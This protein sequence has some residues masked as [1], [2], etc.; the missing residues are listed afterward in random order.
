MVGVPH[1]LAGAQRADGPALLVKHVGDDVD[2]G[3]AGRAHAPLLLVGRRVELAQP[4]A[5]GQQVV[6]G[7][8][9]AAEGEG[10]GAMPR[11]LDLGEV[12]VGDPGEIDA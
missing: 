3:I 4:A 12:G 7:K 11:V 5:E 2:V 6:A 1:R 9:L 8:A 10:Q